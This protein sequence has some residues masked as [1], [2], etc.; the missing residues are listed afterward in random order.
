[1]GVSVWARCWSV[2]TVAFWRCSGG[3]GQLIPELGIAAPCSRLHLD[4]HIP[5]PQQRCPVAIGAELKRFCALAH[6]RGPAC[7]A[8]LTPS[9]P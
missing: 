8:L 2:G 6:A 5:G 4:L 1:M 9:P 3:C 7:Y